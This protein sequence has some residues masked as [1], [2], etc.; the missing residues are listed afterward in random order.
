MPRRPPPSSSLSP[1]Q[2]DTKHREIELK[3]QITAADADKLQRHPLLKNYG[4]GKPQRED[5]LSTYYDTGDFALK[6]LHAA[7]RV[8]RTSRGWLQTFKS[9][10]EQHAALTR[11]NEWEAPVAGAALELDALRDLV[12]KQ[13]YWGKFLRDADLQP[14][15]TT[16]FTRTAWNLHLPGGHVVEL[17]LDRGAVKHGRRQDAISEIEL[18]LK[19]GSTYALFECAL[20]LLE[21]IPLQLGSLSKAERG[22]ALR[23]AKQAPKALNAAVLQ[24]QADMTV[25]DAYRAIF[26]ACLAQIE[27]NQA[28]VCRG[29]D[30]EGLHQ[31]RIGLRRLQ[32]ALDLFHSVI[33]VPPPLQEQLDWLSSHLGP[34][35]DWDV[36]A[37]VTLAPLARASG[38]GSDLYRLQRATLDIA[39]AMHHH[40]S[41]EIRSARFTA[42]ILGCSAWLESSVWRVEDYRARVRD[43]ILYAPITRFAQKCLKRSQRR[44]LARSKKLDIDDGRGCHKLRL[45]TKAARYDAEFFH[46][47]YAAKPAKSAHAY[48]KTLVALQDELGQGNDA[49]VADRLLQELAA[50][51]PELQASISFARGHLRADPDSRT[52]KLRHLLKRLEATP[53]PARK[54]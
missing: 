16:E 43:D 4:V 1:E 52:R 18:E 26:S 48:W 31:M 54:S 27:G 40:L 44:V 10:G 47:L 15:F 14:V 41:A 2:S 17:A 42:L 19:A 32:S 49:E 8:R 12:G 28:A 6:D 3:L 51:R 25:E 7:L 50:A 24:L 39:R 29:E 46:S 9:G 53:L 13:T 21:T 36:L 20:R 34:A 11:R 37:R 35:R 38:K 5:L 45:A 23:H 30:Q 22:Y 33:P